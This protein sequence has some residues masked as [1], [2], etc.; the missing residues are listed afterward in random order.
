MHRVELDDRLSLVTGMLV[1]THP[2]IKAI[3]DA[4][5]GD[6]FPWYAVAVLTLCRHVLRGTLWAA[7]LLL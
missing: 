7:L 3:R 2:T 5:T 1:K 6:T 4:S